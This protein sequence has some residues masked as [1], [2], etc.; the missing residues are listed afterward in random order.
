MIRVGTS[1]FGYHDWCPSFYPQ[2]L[3]YEDYLGHYAKCLDCCELNQ[4]FFQMPSPAGLERYVA[5]VP[6]TFAFTVKLHRR[7][8]HERGGSLT[9]ARRFAGALAPLLEAR[10]LGVVIAQFPFS[11]V[12]H[13]HNRAYLCRVRA[14][15]DLPLVVELRNETWRHPETIDFLRGWGIGWV[16][17]DGPIPEALAPPSG[18]ATSSTG[19]IRLHGRDPLHWWCRDHVFRYQYRYRRRE[20]LAWIPRAREIARRTEEVF[21]IFNNRGLGHAAENALALRRMLRKTR[22]GNTKSTG[23]DT[24]SEAACTADTQPDGLIPGF[25]SAMIGSF[26]RPRTSRT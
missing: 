15:L 12:N 25:G 8:T 19:Y 17:A 3:P 20:L 24:T 22:R 5:R 23:P 13:P 7:L 16:A 10:K 21:V 26:M 9:M 2:G 6:E 11:F 4:T 18:L 14:A 1:G